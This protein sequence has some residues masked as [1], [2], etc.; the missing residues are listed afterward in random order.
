M[1]LV[2]VLINIIQSIPSLPYEEEGRRLLSK[3]EKNKIRQLLIQLKQKRNK[4]KSEIKQ[5]INT[6]RRKIKQLRNQLTKFFG[7]RFGWRRKSRP[8][9]PEF[10]ARLERI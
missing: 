5:L 9:G 7:C 2:S 3:K 6:K 1:I 4:Y 8:R 10:R